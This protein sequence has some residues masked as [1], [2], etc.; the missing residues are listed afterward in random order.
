MLIRTRE[1]G[2]SFAVAVKRRKGDDESCFSVA[3][4]STVRCGFGRKNER[5]GI[6]VNSFRR[7]LQRGCREGEESWNYRQTPEIGDS[8]LLQRSPSG[9]VEAGGRPG[10]CFFRKCENVSRWDPPRRI[11]TGPAAPIPKCARDSTRTRPLL[12]C[13]SMRFQLVRLRI[14]ER[15]V[16]NATG[17]QSSRELALGFARKRSTS[18]AFLRDG[19]SS[20][21]PSA[22]KLRG[23]QALSSPSLP[24][25]YNRGDITKRHVTKEA[26]RS[27]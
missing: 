12:T 27:R 16:K 3:A 20:A 1:R 23:D 6:F 10:D 19:R 11:T 5:R 26:I 9:T 4:S 24:S 18:A 17:R 13:K 7:K 14:A 15:Y 21:T 2:K 8:A 22:R 25:L